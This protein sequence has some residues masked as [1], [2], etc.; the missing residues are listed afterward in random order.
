MDISNSLKSFFH[1]FRSG[2]HQDPV[3]D[4]LI[5]LTLSIFTFICIVVWNAWAFDT[6]AQGGAIG[7]TATSTLPVF[8]SSSIDTINTVFEKRAAEEAKYVT[9]VYRF[10]DPSQ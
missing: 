8:N 9:G 3:R 7:K 1:R 2:V 5:L 4:W 10:T 6:V